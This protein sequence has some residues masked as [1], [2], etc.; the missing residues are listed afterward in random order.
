[1]IFDSPAPGLVHLPNKLLHPPSFSDMSSARRGLTNSPVTFSEAPSTLTLA[2]VTLLE[3]TNVTALVVLLEKK[4]PLVTPPCQL[5]WPL[6]FLLSAEQ[7]FLVKAPVNTVLP[8]TVSDGASTHLPSS[9]GRPT[10]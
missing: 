3:V 4:W 7:V 2:F 10:T 6:C 5:N 9:G 1:M 8:L